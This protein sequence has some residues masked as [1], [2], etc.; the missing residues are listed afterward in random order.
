MEARYGALTRG[1]WRASRS[2]FQAR[3]RGRGR[4]RLPG[5]TAAGVIAVASPSSSSSSA[6][7]DQC[8][9]GERELEPVEAGGLVSM[10]VSLARRARARERE[11]IGTK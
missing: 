1:T 8:T 9:R 2:L 4:G 11:G 10:L 3:R 6:D 5:A 7:V